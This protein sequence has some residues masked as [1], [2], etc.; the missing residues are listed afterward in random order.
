MFSKYFSSKFFSSKYFPRGSSI[1]GVYENRGDIVTKV[2]KNYTAAG[3]ISTIAGLEFT[4]NGDVRSLVLTR[5]EHINVEFEGDITT[6]L[7]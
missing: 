6:Q 7:T 2:I 5:P 1:A 4:K 3:D